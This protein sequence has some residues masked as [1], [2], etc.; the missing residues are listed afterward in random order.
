M[1][2]FAKSCSLCTSYIYLFVDFY[3]FILEFVFEL[4]LEETL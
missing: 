1:R 4:S 2:I 3:G